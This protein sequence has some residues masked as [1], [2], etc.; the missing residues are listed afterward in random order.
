[1]GAGLAVLKWVTFGVCG[2]EC[3]AGCSRGRLPTVSNLC[4][5]HKVLVPVVLG[6]LAFHLMWEKK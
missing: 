1:V 5:R 3:V 2:Y 4:G 6:G